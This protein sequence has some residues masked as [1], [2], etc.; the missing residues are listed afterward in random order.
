MEPLMEPWMEQQLEKTNAVS[1]GFLVPAPGVHQSRGPIYR[2]H[3]KRIRVF[4]HAIPSVPFA[5]CSSRVQTKSH[6][7]G[8]SAKRTGASTKYTTLKSTSQIS[9]R[10]D[11]C[12]SLRRENRHPVILSSGITWRLHY[13]RPLKIVPIPVAIQISSVRQWH[14]GMFRKT[15]EDISVSVDL[16][17]AMIAS[18]VTIT[19]GGLSPYHARPT[20]RWSMSFWRRLQMRASTLVNSKTMKPGPVRR[21]L[22][23][24][25]N[26]L[27]RD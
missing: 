3:A 20:A 7:R 18:S 14:I 15:A 5:T 24:E 17:T 4:H 12:A 10:R 1:I 11:G 25:P 13:S 23:P 27:K 6:A 9:R 26:T 8:I 16:N 19:L 2:I 22:Y 21:R